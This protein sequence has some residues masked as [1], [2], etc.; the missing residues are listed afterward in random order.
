MLLLVH[1][2]D[3]NFTQR[4]PCSHNNNPS[5]ELNRYVRVCLVELSLCFF[6]IY[7]HPVRLCIDSDKT[8]LDKAGVIHIV[9]ASIVFQLMLAVQV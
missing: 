8:K 9:G 3:I 2:D 7:L 1:I 6:H 5:E 4:L